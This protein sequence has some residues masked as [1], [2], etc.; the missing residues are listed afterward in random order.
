VAPSLPWIGALPPCR[1][2][3]MQLGALHGLASSG[4]SFGRHGAVWPVSLTREGCPGPVVAV[5]REW[6]SSC[7]SAPRRERDIRA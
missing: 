2:A 1:P 4:A 3:K 5:K 7:E 6:A